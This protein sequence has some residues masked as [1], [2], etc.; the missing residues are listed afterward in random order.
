MN[1][2]TTLL[3]ATGLAASL[4]G[5]NSILKPF[6]LA[7]SGDSAAENGAALAEAQDEYFQE[8]L[9]TGKT[10]LSHGNFA[11][12]M[13]A[14]RHASLGRSTRAEALNGLGVAYVGIGRLDLARRYFYQAASLAPSDERFAANVA[15]LHRELNRADE[16]TM[17]ARQ[18][19]AL[20][21]PQVAAAEAGTAVDQAGL[22]SLA[23]TLELAAV[24]APVRVQ[25]T[26]QPAVRVMAGGAI[27]VGAPSAQINRVNKREVAITTHPASSP[28]SIR[29]AARNT[30]KAEYPVRIDLS[31]VPVEDE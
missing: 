4:G 1:R 3:V 11:S 21:A 13:E 25:A 20:D 29:V 19:E 5:C 7:R 10:H 22:A 9:A 14:F 24:Q 18:R 27:R 8:R 28:A 30:A 6:G 15:R 16:E 23:G 26:P 2:I 12:A 17:L 31:E